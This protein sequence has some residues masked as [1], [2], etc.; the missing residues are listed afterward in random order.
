MLTMKKHLCLSFLFVCFVATSYGQWEWVHPTPQGNDIRSL[1]FPTA[2]TGYAGADKG[3]ILKTTNGG[4]GW[5]QL[6]TDHMAAVTGIY[7]SS[8]NDGLAA[9]K[10]YLLM[11][12]D[13]GL[14]WNTRYRF[15]D[16]NLE[17]MQFLNADS[18][19]VSG[20]FLGAWHLRFTADSGASFQSQFISF[21][22]ITAYFFL[23]DG[24]GWISFAD[25]SVQ[26]SGDFGMT[27]N[28][29]GIMNST[30]FNSIQFVDA[31]NGFA[32]ADN[33]EIWNSNDGG[34]TWNSSVNPATGS[35]TIYYTLHFTSASNGFVSGQDGFLVSTSDGGATWTVNGQAGWFSGYAFAE[36]GSAIYLAGTEGE[37]LASTDNGSTWNSQTTDLL[38]GVSLNGITHTTAGYY[39]CGDYGSLLGGNG[40]AWSALNS[41]T[42][43]SLYGIT[44]STSANGIICGEA[45]VIVRTSNSGLN[46]N[47]V[48]SGVSVNLW[49]VSHSGSV[50]YACG[51][52]ETLIK[53]VNGGQNWTPVTTPLSGTG[54]NYMQVLF[55]VQDSGYVFTDQNDLLYTTDGGQS[56]NVSNVPAQGVITDAWF[57]DGLNGWICTDV[58]EIYSTTD[59]GINW[60]FLYQYFQPV[61]LNGIRFINPLKGFAYGDGVMLQTSDGGNY[62][63]EEY[64]PSTKKIN[65]ISINGNELMAA[66]GG[67][68]SLLHRF[69][70]ATLSIPDVNLCMEN[71]YSG[72]FNY[73]GPTPNRNGI[74]QLSDENGDF[75]NPYVIGTIQPGSNSFS[76]FVPGGIVDGTGYR[77]RAYFTNPPLIS[78]VS[79]AKTILIAP[80]VQVQPSGPT[81]FCPGDSVILFFTGNPGWTYQWFRDS[82]AIPGETGEYITVFTTGNYTVQVYDV[83]CNYTSQPID[84]VV[85]CTGIASVQQSPLRVAPNPTSGIVNISWPEK[86]GINK[87]RLTELNGRVLQE[88]TVEGSNAQLD[89]SGYSQGV[90]LLS[91]PGRA[92]AALRIVRQ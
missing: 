45:G 68:A 35:S 39:V 63:S 54:Y 82:V 43:N 2:Q 88:Y 90:Y 84:V 29:L 60:N 75:Y 51:D 42:S 41:N 73:S 18:G 67:R 38:E 9:Q 59:G 26:K 16:L 8:A 19:W 49:S 44:F 10:E 5:S 69:E 83:Q 52:N 81:V 1:C 6:Y 79:D 14:T 91:V 7:F 89:I 61:S 27:W 50:L 55:P 17:K 71:T 86:S 53:S 20:E 74:I 40:S 15:S 92:S 36:T 62:W 56:W 13:G 65:A 21:D 72:S 32:C 37:I 22:R 31:M 25:G 66:G 80:S 33:G 87:L 70:N 47:P 64:Y 57:I 48:V 30:G 78:E 24:N 11:T 28:N 76:Y 3:I 85:S 23:P 4:T 34:V 77:I 46:W 58:N 12:H